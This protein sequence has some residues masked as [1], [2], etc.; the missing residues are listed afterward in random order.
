[1][2]CKFYYVFLS[3]FITLSFQFEGLFQQF[4]KGRSGDKRLPVIPGRLSV[5]SVFVDT[6]AGCS[7]FSWWCFSCSILNIR[8][9]FVACKGS[10]EKFDVQRSLSLYHVSC[11]IL[12]VS[13]LCPMCWTWNL[14]YYMLGK[15][16]TNWLYLQPMCLTFGGLIIMCFAVYVTFISFGFL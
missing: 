3:P 6:L 16:C 4:L 7:V 13:V 8:S 15:D 5:S 12:K 14:E 9:S 11:L 2:I 1:M 10:T